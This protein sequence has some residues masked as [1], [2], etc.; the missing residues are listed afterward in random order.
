MDISKFTSE[1]QNN[2][3]NLTD[4]S[5]S[6]TR[7]G[8]LKVLGT[9]IYTNIDRTDIHGMYKAA[10]NIFENGNKIVEVRPVSKPYSEIIDYDE[11]KIFKELFRLE[12][13]LA[14][15]HY[16]SQQN[17][18]SAGVVSFSMRKNY[19]TNILK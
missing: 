17:C 8:F 19:S 7:R 14:V 13:T 5:N 2:S 11:Y 3:H 10:Y 1:N 15:Q 4:L 9:K 18:L 6:Y 16:I 12:F